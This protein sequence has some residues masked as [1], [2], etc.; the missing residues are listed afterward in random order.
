[1]KNN[2]A[3]SQF[4]KGKCLQK[5]V[6][7]TYGGTMS[8]GQDKAQVVRG[9]CLTCFYLNFIDRGES[10]VCTKYNFEPKGAVESCPGFKPIAEGLDELIAKMKAQGEWLE[11]VGQ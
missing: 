9:K 5:N 6:R 10:F 2:Q 4:I 7:K 3:R 11:G 8:F 1:M